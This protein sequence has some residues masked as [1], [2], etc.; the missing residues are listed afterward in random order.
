MLTDLVIAG[1][2]AIQLLITGE[3]GREQVA[4]V[5]QETGGRCGV[6][7][8]HCQLRFRTEVAKESRIP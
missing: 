4:G 1:N 3:G 6:T 8:H 2:R 7:P 5:E